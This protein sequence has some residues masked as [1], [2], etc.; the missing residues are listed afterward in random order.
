[1]LSEFYKRLAFQSEE[2]MK[3]N[4]G[5]ND[6]YVLPKTLEKISGTIGRS[7]TLVGSSHMFQKAATAME[8]KGE[9]WFTK[10]NER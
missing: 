6:N 5:Y 7:K 2:R 1:M 9:Q 4:A 8:L 3:C 10:V